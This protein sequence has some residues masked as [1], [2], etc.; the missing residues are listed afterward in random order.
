MTKENADLLRF[1]RISCLGLL[2]DEEIWSLGTRLSEHLIVIRHLKK[3]E[4]ASNSMCKQSIMCKII[5]CFPI[6]EAKLLFS[7]IISSDGHAK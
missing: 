3:L 1:L 2:E 6:K 4:S 7:A 5:S